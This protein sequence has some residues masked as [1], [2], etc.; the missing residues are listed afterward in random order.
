MLN[1]AP[2]GNVN[3]TN[4]VLITDFQLYILNMAISAPQDEQDGSPKN[5]EPPHIKS[6]SSGWSVKPPRIRQQWVCT[7]SW[8]KLLHPADYSE[9][10]LQQGKDVVEEG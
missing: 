10:E 7:R 5:A 6:R 3:W 9:W 4:P 1:I 8:R 2:H